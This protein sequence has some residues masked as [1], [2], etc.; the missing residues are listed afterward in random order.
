MTPLAS[1]FWSLKRRRYGHRLHLM[2]WL[3]LGTLGFKRPRYL[4]SRVKS[5]RCSWL[6]SVTLLTECQNSLGYFTCKNRNLK[7]KK[8]N[9]VRPLQ[10][11]YN[12]YAKNYYYYYYYY[13]AQWDSH[14]IR[15]PGWLLKQKYCKNFDSWV[16][17]LLK[18]RSFQI[19]NAIKLTGLDKVILK[20]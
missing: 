9:C 6:K 5:Q 18:P 7:W 2:R 12:N 11:C 4:S 20:S 19:G 3:N 15:V 8:T 13:Y 1:N 17:S 14:R 16:G 10:Y